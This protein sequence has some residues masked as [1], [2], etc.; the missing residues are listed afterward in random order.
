[1][2]ECGAVGRHMRFA[3]NGFVRSNRSYTKEMM[4]AHEVMNKTGLRMSLRMALFG[5]LIVLWNQSLLLL[6]LLIETQ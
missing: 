1:M 5:I 3:T 4:V 6:L 2:S